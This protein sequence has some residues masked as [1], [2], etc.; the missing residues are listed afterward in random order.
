MIKV[1]LPNL[2]TDD[3]NINRKSTLRSE[4]KVR[5]ETA[6]PTRSQNPTTSKEPLNHSKDPTY[7]NPPQT[8]LNINP[9]PLAG[10]ARNNVLNVEFTT[11][12]NKEARRTA[13]PTRSPSQ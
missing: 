13:K 4:T 3:L 12:F 1:I 10:G 8:D 11:P 6:H 2:N 5:H 7:T 9:I